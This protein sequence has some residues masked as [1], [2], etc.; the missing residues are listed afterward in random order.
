MERK[1]ILGL[2][3]LLLTASAAQEARIDIIVVRG[4]I[5]IDYIP[6]LAYASHEKIPVIF[7]QPEKIQKDVREALSLYATTSKNLLIIGGKKAITESVENE[8]R[9]IGFYVSRLWDW[10]RYGTAAR[11][12]IELWKTSPKAIIVEAE[13]VDDLLYAEAAALKTDSPV[14]FTKQNELPATTKKALY[15][16]G[17]EKVIVIGNV[18]EKVI[19][20]IKSV[21]KEVKVILHPEKKTSFEE[22]EKTPY[23]FNQSYIYL[24]I[25][26]L[27]FSV[28]IIVF[29][30]RKKSTRFIVLDMDEEKIVELLKIHGTLTQKRIAE[31]SGFSKPKT[32][33][34]LRSLLEKG[35]IEK[36]KHKK[37]QKI[38]LKSR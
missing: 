1:I 11:I 35:V 22:F 21:S 30:F 13:E 31:L 16:L 36:I 10:D 3:A 33:R 7:V 12:A 5:L 17:V 8:L 37:T 18:S 23:R 6:A 14:L 28:G 27:L 26:I 32:S 38:K 29:Y 9:A 20:E 25:F 15:T 2:V 19:K 34:V 4:D 24:F